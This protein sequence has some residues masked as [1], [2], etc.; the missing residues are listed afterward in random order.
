MRHV[1]VAAFAVS[2]LA[3]PATRAVAQETERV[4]RTV[5]LP[6]GGTLQ[7][8]NF[9]GHVTI[10]GTDRPEVV[11]DAVRRGTRTQ[12]DR[13]TLDV[14]AEGSTV[15][16]DANHKDWSWMDWA[17]K[18]VVETDLDVRVP[19][20]TNLDVDVFSSPVEVRGVDGSYRVHAFSGGIR[21]MDATGSVDAHTFSGAV[22]IEERSVGDGQSVVVNTFSGSVDIRVPESAQGTVDFHSF[23]GQLTSG[24]PLRFDET[25]SRRSLTARLGA[26]VDG[27]T[28][29][30]KT[31][32]G[33]LHIGR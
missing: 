32:S 11:V 31:F 23:S 29:R 19:R 9:S 33:N 7:L 15:I 17:R 5:P 21:L 30:V 2:V 25:G 18:N 4:S 14:H 24:L 13:I 3:A 22:D 16:V 1:L 8:K 6:P 10:T 12:L 20:R 28:F 27:A 26:G